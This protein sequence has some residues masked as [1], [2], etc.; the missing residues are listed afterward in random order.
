MHINKTKTFSAN[1]LWNHKDEKTTN[2]KLENNNITVIQKDKDAYYESKPI[3]ITTFKELVLS[4]NVRDLKSATITFQVKIGKDNNFSEAFTMGIWEKD[5]ATASADSEDSFAKLSHD[6]LSNNDK[7][8][9]LIKLIVLIKPNNDDTFKINNI[10]VTTKKDDTPLFVNEEILEEIELKVPRVNQLSIPE[11]GN[12]IC[13]PTSVTMLLNFN[14]YN[15]DAYTTSQMV[16]DHKFGIYG[17]WTFNVG[18]AGSHN[19]IYARV[20][21]ILDYSIALD[22]LKKD[23][24]VV[25]S[26]NTKNKEDLPGALSSYPYGHLLVLIGFTKKDGIWHAIINDPAFYKDE[27][28]RVL[29]P[30][31]NV[32]KAHRGYSYIITTNPLN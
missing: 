17:N 11:I 9:N 22:Y 29:Y 14:G 15:Y 25:L 6:I 32:L 18:V 16:K 3:S 24:P 7:D 30:L 10:S 23:I 26:I 13:S 4:W 5:K 2:L 8:N 19:N 27:D 12:K 20:E 1:S 28:V 21:H 31:K